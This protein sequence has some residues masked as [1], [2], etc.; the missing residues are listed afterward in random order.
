V[1][2]EKV[3][4]YAQGGAPERR[5]GELRVDGVVQEVVYA[6]AATRVVVGVGEAERFTM[7]ALLLNV[8]A[9]AAGFTRDQPVTLA[10]DGAAVRQ[11]TVAAEKG[12]S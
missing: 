6:G 4:V 3:R 7:A 9:G 12:N 11:L 8:E 1:R 2:P 5:E 10:W